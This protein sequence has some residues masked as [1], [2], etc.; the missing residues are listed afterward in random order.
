MCI[1]FK[2]MKVCTF[3]VFFRGNQILYTVNGKKRMDANKWGIKCF[4]FF[5]GK[6]WLNILCHCSLKNKN[7]SPTATGGEGFEYLTE[8]I[9]KKT[10]LS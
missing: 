6:I 10:K 1:L 3:K 9:K 7:A 5:M 2:K 4:V 8:R